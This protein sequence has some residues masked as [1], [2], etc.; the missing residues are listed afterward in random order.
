MTPPQHLL[1]VPMRFMG[2]TVLTIPLL[3]NLRAAFPESRIN[4]LCSKATAPLLTHCPYIDEVLLEAKKLPAR[5]RQL[6]GYDWLISL[7]KSASLAVMAKCAGTPTVIGFDKQRFPWGFRRWGLGLDVSVPFPSL[8]SRRTMGATLLSVLTAVD[9]P[10]DDGQ[11]ELWEGSEPSPLSPTEKPVAVVHA[12]SHSTGKTFERSVFEDS[13]H[14]L[15]S[16]GWHVV[17]IGTAQDAPTYDGWPIENLAGQTSLLQTVALL[18]QAQFYLG[19]DSGPLHL[20]A[21][22]GVPRIVGLYGPTNQQ[23]WG[24]VG[25]PHFHPVFIDLPCRPCHP[26][27]CSHNQCRT[28][29]TGP[30][31]LERVQKSFD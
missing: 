19:V 27:V 6:Q 1:V 29:M 23:Q 11:L 14:W 28:L 12:V 24:P 30:Q 22:A 2:D 4:V 3:R 21:A 8:R 25:V 10:V 26:Q 13:I 17:G 15:S 5:F 20:A 7:R 31:V 9:V 16:Q 18:R